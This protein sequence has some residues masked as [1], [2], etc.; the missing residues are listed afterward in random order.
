MDLSK[1]KFTSMQGLYHSELEILQLKFN[2]LKLTNILHPDRL[3]RLHT[4]ELR[5]NKLETMSG[6]NLPYLRHLYL[7]ENKIKQ[8]NGI[9]SLIR[10]KLLH[11]RSNN[12]DN[13]DGFSNKM[14]KLTYLNLR[15]NKLS[16]FNEII[17]L[18]CLPALK[19]LILLVNQL[20]E[21]REE[22]T[23]DVLMHIPGLARV[24]KVTVTNKEQREAK[25][26]LKSLIAEAEK[27]Q[28]AEEEDD[29]ASDDNDP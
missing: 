3:T 20:E 11:L 1:N 9:D 7:A 22:M 2:K 17:K 28:T 21:D 25:K 8:L 27:K 6:F 14:T 16:D 23:T 24:D 29:H 13:L 15:D 12:I 10:I 4:L 18:K 19:Q 5:G 26:K